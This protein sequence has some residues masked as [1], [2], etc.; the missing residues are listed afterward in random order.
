M[1][2]QLID[3]SNRI[4]G[5]WTVI[6]F[7]KIYKSETFWLCECSCGREKSVRAESLK[8]GES[9]SCGCSKRAKLEGMIFGHLTVLGFHS[10]DENGRT[11]WE[12][13]CDCGGMKVAKEHCLMSGNVKTC[14]CRMR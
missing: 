8:S 5:Q 10:A 1:G 9:I 4:F 14:G 2:R 12:C 7:D 11:K 6:K 13:I 3:L